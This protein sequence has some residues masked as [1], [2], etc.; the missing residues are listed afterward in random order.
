[1]LFKWEFCDWSD[2]YSRVYCP[3]LAYLLRGVNMVNGSHLNVLCYLN[4]SLDTGLTNVQE[5]TLH[6]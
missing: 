3:L 4:G 6:Y 2:K 5:F 1:M